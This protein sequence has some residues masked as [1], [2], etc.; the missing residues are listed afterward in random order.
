MEPTALELARYI[1]SG[2]RIVFGQ[3]CGEPTTLVEALIEQGA[4]IGDLSAFIATS[5]SGAFT[6]ESADAFRLSSMGAIGALRTM[7]KAGKLDVVPTHVGQ[8]APLIEAGI[9]GCDV[10]MV[11]VSPADANGHHSFGLTSDHTK[12]MVSAARVVIA[13]VNDQVPFTYGETLHAREID[14]AVEVSCCP[15]QVLPASSLR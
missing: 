2:D 4:A 1:R 5:F 14:V 15:V 8:I 7:T 11:Q 3:A 12:A 6:P 10:A 9:I 13:E